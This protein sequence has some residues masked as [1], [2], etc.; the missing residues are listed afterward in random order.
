MEPLPGEGFTEFAGW[1]QSQVLELLGAAA[2]EFAIRFYRECAGCVL[3]EWTG[4]V[5]EA[6]EG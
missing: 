1:N 3:M 2:R 5:A 6:L 4:P